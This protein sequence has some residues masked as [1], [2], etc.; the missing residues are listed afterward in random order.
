[1]T[2]TGVD[3]NLVD[4]TITS[5]ITITVDDANSDNNFDPVAD[6][7]VSTSTTDNDVAGFTVVETDGSTSVDESGTTDTFTIVLNAQPA[8]DVVLSIASGT[9]A[10]STVSPASITFTSANWDTPQT[11]TSTGV[12]DAGIIDG[13]QVS[14]V[15]ISIV[16][17]ASDDSFD[18]VANQ[19]VNVTTTDDDVPGFTV[20]ESGG[21]TSV[22]ETGTTD[23]FTV[24][25]DAQ[26]TNNVV[27]DIASADTGEATIAPASLTFTAGNWNTPQTVTVTG[28]NDGVL[29]DGDQ[30]SVITISINQSGS[31]DGFDALADKTVTATTADDDIPGFTIAETGGSTQVAESGTTDTFTVVLSAQPTSD[32]VF[33]IS[34]VDST[35]SSVTSTLTFTNGNWNTPQTVTVTGVDDFLIDGT[36]TAAITVSIDDANSNSEFALTP[37]QSVNVSTLDNDTAGFTVTETDGSTSVNESGVN[38]TFTIVLTA[39]PVSDVVLTI[40]SS[41]NTESSATSTV[42]FTTNNWNTA[43]SVQVTAVDEFIID[44]NQNSTL[45]IS[46]DDANSDNDFDALADQTVTVQTIDNDVAGF[47]IIETGGDTTV[48]ESGTSDTFGVVLTAQP[49]SNVEITI[50]QPANPSS[51]GLEKFIFT[52][53]AS[54]EASVSVTTL[55][56]TP[57]NWNVP[58]DVTVTGANDYVIDGTEIYEIA[59]SINPNNSDDDFDAVSPETVEGTNLD[60][61]F[62]GFII[63]ETEGSTVVNENGTTDIFTVI[64]TAEPYEDVVLTIESSDTEEATVSSSVTFT[65]EN[66][67]VPQEVVLVGVDDVIIDKDQPADITV[68]ISGSESDDNFDVVASQVVAATILDDEPDRDDD[69][70]LDSEDPCPDDPD[71]DDDGLRD[72]EEPT[73][74]CITN[75]D[76]DN[77]GLPDGD[78]P[79]E[80]CITDP[81]C[82]DDGIIDGAEIPIC[83]TSPDCDGDGIPDPDEIPMCITLGDCDGD[84]ISDPNEE[85]GC[86]TLSDCD[87]DGLLDPDE[88][89]GC[90]TIPDCDG[91]GILD[92][93]EEPGCAKIADCDNDTI[94]DPDEEPG[95]I[96]I[97]DCDSD[98]LL[99]P[100]EEPGCITIPDCDGDSIL[101]PDEEPG[102]AA[103]PDCDG[104]SILD[105]DEEPGCVHFADCDN[106]SIDDP[107]EEPGCITIKDCDEDGTIDGM[108]PE[109]CV[110]DPSCPGDEGVVPP[111]TSTT[112]PTTTT[113][114][115]T[116]KGPEKEAQSYWWLWLIIGILGFAAGMFFLFLF[117]K[118]RS[119]P[120]LIAIT[121]SPSA[122]DVEGFTNIS[123]ESWDQEDEEVVETSWYSRFIREDEADHFDVLLGK[124]THKEL[125]LGIV[126]GKETNQAQTHSTIIY[127]PDE[128]L[129]VHE[130]PVANAEELSDS[131]GLITLVTWH[132][133]LSIF[134]STSYVVE[135]KIGN[136]WVAVAEASDLENIEETARKENIDTSMIRLVAKQR[137]MKP[138]ISSLAPIGVALFS[139]ETLAEVDD[140]EITNSEE[141]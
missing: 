35:E 109:G 13:S 121:I 130:I 41:D 72:N 112:I 30:D 36:I 62:A 71:C 26:P 63:T 81:D 78:E 125:H 131:Q 108:E 90:I 122:I 95:C 98:G 99:D 119:T 111:V 80:S 28:V 9:V 11:I 40:V 64:L 39:Q 34:P 51:S 115:P 132:V 79:T 136:S 82:D 97:P 61:D 137:F 38:D 139:E 77:D 87:E 59:V 91:D 21:S 118:R 140:S 75:P 103:K 138:Q 134:K 120:R 8:E 124:D 20:V 113:S 73:V 67:N 116:E 15:T 32:V 107:D 52:A 12:D 44:G 88:E 133:P 57:A 117:Y 27:F 54:D 86:V 85:P 53:G 141:E 49:S 25:L 56:F 3:D 69:Y 66:W 43:Q 93:D 65:P 10:E 18:A 47:E 114:A 128:S 37:D 46:V 105:P 17:L 110:L 22:S 74:E 29:I 83:V 2:V 42:T 1:M 55:T 33:S 123:T 16:P 68:S 48:Q 94:L 96:T 102:C 84:G 58:Q 60:D 45:T 106:D 4:G 19:T 5:T 126:F 76:C 14:V 92:P 127:G 104:D 135:A 50:S 31:D 129:P 70:I 100:D 23:T 89:P 7:T 101:D 24:V 6:Q